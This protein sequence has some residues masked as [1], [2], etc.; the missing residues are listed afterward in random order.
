MARKLVAYTNLESCNPCKAIHPSLL[1]IAQSHEVEF[2]H[3]ATDR[4]DFIEAGVMSTPTFHIIEDGEKVAEL[5]GLV[6][7][8][9]LIAALTG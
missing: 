8:N 1:T 7:S 5:R 6:T 2:K 3:L 9:E 4:A